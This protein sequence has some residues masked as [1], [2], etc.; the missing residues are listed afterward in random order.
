MERTITEHQHDDLNKA[1]T[2]TAGEPGPFGAPNSYLIRWYEQ[3][4]SGAEVELDFQAGAAGE[5]GVNGITC[6]ALIVPMLDRLRAFQDGPLKCTENEMVIHHLEQALFFC[7]ARS[8]RRIQAG[9][10]GTAVPLA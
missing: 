3:D 7:V 6:E 9:V 8:E 4:E 5:A 10:K 2:I 1:L